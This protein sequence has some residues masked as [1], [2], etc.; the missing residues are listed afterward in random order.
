MAAGLSQKLIRRE[1]PLTEATGVGGYSDQHDFSV[2][3]TLAKVWV[4]VSPPLALEIRS[5][6]WSGK[7]RQNK[8]RCQWV[9]G[10]VLQSSSI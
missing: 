5:S 1:A 10:F 7:E 3:R 4:M 6:D 9:A 8:T 2:T